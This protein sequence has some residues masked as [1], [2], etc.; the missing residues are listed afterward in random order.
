MKG[1]FFEECK[2][3]QYLKVI[4]DDYMIYSNFVQ[5]QVHK[6]KMT[7]NEVEWYVAGML[8]FYFLFHF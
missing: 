8:L 6:Q 5:L 4:V 7:P 2:N 3:I 1:N